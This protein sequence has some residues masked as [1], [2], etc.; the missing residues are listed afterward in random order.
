MQRLPHTLNVCP[1]QDI[2]VRQ[3]FLKT[4][5]MLCTPQ[6]IAH[7]DL[8]SISTEDLKIL[9][10]VEPWIRA[11]MAKEVRKVHGK[12]EPVCPF[13][14]PALDRQLLFLSVAK[15][16]ESDSTEAVYREMKLYQEIFQS[17][18][19][20]KSPMSVLKSLVVIFP[21]TSGHVI[22]AAVDPKQTPLKT[23]LLQND[24]MIGEF[25]PTCPLHASWD[26]SF[27]PLQSPVPFYALRS[28]IETDWRFIHSEREWRRIYKSR[29]GEPPE[30][31][32][33]KIPRR[34]VRLLN[35]VGKRRFRSD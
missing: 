3:I 17:F 30:G 16:V 11:F 1:A 2:D 18:G 6:M 34:L 14:P 33:H 23:E 27:F 22:L 24:I 35:R 25:F 5:R 15:P 26:P 4:N 8:D 29:F 7:G 20:R 9:R 10:T 31:D 28:F 21:E 13:V 32:Q 19:L 12:V